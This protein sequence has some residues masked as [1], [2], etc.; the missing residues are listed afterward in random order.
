MNIEIRP[1]GH[2]KPAVKPATVP[3]PGPE[4]P[5]GAWRTAV[6]PGGAAAGAALLAQV[7]TYQ[8]AVDGPWG[9]YVTGVVCAA[10]GAALAAGWCLAGRRRCGAWVAPLLAV[11]VVLPGAALHA[12]RLQWRGTAVQVSLGSPLEFRK[13]LD[14]TLKGAATLRPGADA[15]MLRAPAGSVGY[16][17]V[18]PLSPQSLP[19]DVP[20]ALLAPPG[21]RVGEEVAW[22]ASVERDAEYFVLVETDRLLVQLTSWGLVVAMTTGDGPVEGRDVARQ[23]PNGSLQEWTL[24]RAGGRAALLHGGEE[25][26][27]AAHPDPFRYVRLGET[28]TDREHGGTLRLHSLRLARFLEA[29]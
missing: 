21:P 2:R 14:P 11:L 19:W 13:A 4:P 27:T 26:W 16:L 20:R 8:E 23:V 10:L 9:P 17:E 22:R 28:R 25:I 24:R 5:A 6:W 29:P 15:V 3:A 12:R 7:M 18:R 1:L